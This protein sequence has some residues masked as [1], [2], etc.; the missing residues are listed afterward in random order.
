MGHCARRLGVRA[1]TLACL[2][3]PPA[4]QAQLAPVGVPAG[5]VRVE[6]DGA[7]DI[8][9]FR[10]RD[11]SFEAPIDTMHP[12]ATVRPGTGNA[13]CGMQFIWPIK[14]EYVV[15]F[16]VGDGEA[17]VGTRPPSLAGPSATTSGSWPGRR[18]W[19][20]RCMRTCCAG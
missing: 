19:T 13:V 8:W 20:T 5:V 9:D 2:L 6:L 14:G 18:A 4:V 7:M 1:G 16:A 10:Y 3:V 11:G 15:A 17:A 12:V